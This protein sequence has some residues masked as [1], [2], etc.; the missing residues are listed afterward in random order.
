MERRAPTRTH[1]RLAAALLL[2]AAACRADAQP[3]V[4]D[5]SAELRPASA[6]VVD[7][8]LPIEEALRRF[9][10][11]AGPPPEALSGA[12][13]R[14]SLVVAFVAAVER[15]DTAALA[16]L[17]LTAAE[18]GA[19]YYPHSRFTA[20]PYQLAPELLW[21]QIQNEQGRGATRLLRRFAGAPLG[22]L[23]YA[24]EPEPRTEGPNRVWERCRLRLRGERGDTVALRLFGSVLERGG[25]WRL[26]SLSND[27]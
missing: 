1:A 20:P 13:T 24:C 15:A 8:I 25:A 4:S 11:A 2:G 10:A 3:T 9:Q 26:M 12:P 27:L 5:P 21:L 19:F 17:P 22:Y 7:S 18:F 23:G 14:D 6:P 16:A